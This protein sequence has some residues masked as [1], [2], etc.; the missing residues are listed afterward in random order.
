MEVRQLTP[1]ASVRR[2][3]KYKFTDKAIENAVKLLDAGESA[4]IGPCA[5]GIKEAR[6]AAQTLKRMITDVSQFENEDLR[7][8]AWEEDGKGFAIVQ[9]KG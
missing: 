1:P 9:V 2:S 7:T 3:S 8:K 5:D 4:G 6:S